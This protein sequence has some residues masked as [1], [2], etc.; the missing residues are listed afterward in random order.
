MK[1]NDECKTQGTISVTSVIYTNMF[2]LYFQPF[3]S[4]LLLFLH[5]T[6]RAL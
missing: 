6:D 2:Y 5:W 3:C 1:D 4:L